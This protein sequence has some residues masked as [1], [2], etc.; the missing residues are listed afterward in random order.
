M[1]HNWYDLYSQSAIDMVHDSC[2]S[3]TVPKWNSRLIVEQE[4]NT[5]LWSWHFLDI[6]YVF[7]FSC[8]QVGL[9]H[10]YVFCA[11][12]CIVVSKHTLSSS[13][14]IYVARLLM[15]ICG[16]VSIL[17]LFQWFFNYN[18]ELFKEGMVLFSIFSHAGPHGHTQMQTWF[19]YS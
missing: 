3:C 13:C 7:T 10:I 18:F 1:A 15:Y 19:I 12:L 5:H 17:P 11:R 8:L 9:C 4:K 6:R 14:V 2:F 16:R